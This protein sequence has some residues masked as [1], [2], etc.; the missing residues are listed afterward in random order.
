MGTVDES[1]WPGGR[2]HG[3]GLVSVSQATCP[4][5]HAGVAAGSWHLFRCY[6]Y[7]WRLG[8]VTDGGKGEAEVRPRSP[9]IISGRPWSHHGSNCFDQKSWEV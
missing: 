1:G 2:Q 8:S 5:K 6:K 7:N 3:V 9:W 4:L